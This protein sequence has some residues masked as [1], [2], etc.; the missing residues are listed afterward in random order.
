MKLGNFA[1][2]HERL[3]TEHITSSRQGLEDDPP[4]VPFQFTSEAGQGTAS[5][6]FSFA[7]P[8]TESGSKLEAPQQSLTAPARPAAVNFS[9]KPSQGVASFQFSFS[10]P[11]S[12]SYSKSEARILA[13]RSRFIVPS[14][15]SGLTTIDVLTEFSLL[16]LGDPSEKGLLDDDVYQ[17]QSREETAL[18]ELH[19]AGTK[20]K[21]PPNPLKQPELGQILSYRRSRN[22]PLVAVMGKVLSTVQKHEVLSFKLAPQLQQDSLLRETRPQMAENGIH[23]FLDMSN[24]NISFQHT[25]R[26]MHNIHDKAIFQPLPLLKLDFL[27]E[28]FVRRRKVVTQNAGCSTKPT[29]RQPLYVQELERLGYQVDLRARRAVLDNKSRRSGRRRNRANQCYCSCDGSTDTDDGDVRYVEDMVDETLQTRIAEAVMEYF[30]TPG[31][32]VLGTGDAQPA[33]Y[34]DGFLTYAERALKMG[35]DVEIVSWSQS[36][37]SRWD[38]PNWMSRWRDRFRIIKLDT[39]IEALLKT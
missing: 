15:R 4:P 39:F 26:E 36:L 37:S 31:T 11:L 30:E 25:L 12:E 10:A 21:T 34:S 2:I 14:A 17:G 7:S 28:I 9:P 13:E 29:H 23:V 3:G 20:T 24:I 1:K 16:G 27:T 22:S 6:N 38:N 35:W 19:I 32:L 18:N 33:S 5:F 8:L